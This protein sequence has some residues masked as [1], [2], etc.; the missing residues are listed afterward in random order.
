[1]C[2]VKLSSTSG[3]GSAD[4]AWTS[5]VCENRETGDAAMSCYLR[6]PSQYRVLRVAS[7][8]AARSVDRDCAGRNASSVKVLSP[9]NHLISVVAEHVCVGDQKSPSEGSTHLRVGT[10]GV[11]VHGMY[12][13][14]VTEHKR[15]AQSRAEANRPWPRAEGQG[16]TTQS[17]AAIL[18]AEVRCPHSSDEAGQLPWSEG[19]YGE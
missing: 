17:Y 16:V 19:G 9:D 4:E 2:V 6:G 13:R 14:L 5:P 10:T 15:S 7:R 12:R 11:Q 18:R 3:C 8:G 1:M